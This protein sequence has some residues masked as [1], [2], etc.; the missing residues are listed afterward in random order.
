MSQEETN[1]EKDMVIKEVPLCSLNEMVDQP[2]IAHMSNDCQEET[3]KELPKN[4]PLTSNDD[5]SCQE[6]ESSSKDSRSDNPIYAFVL[7]PP[8]PHPPS[9]GINPLPIQHHLSISTVSFVQQHHVPQ[10]IQS[11]DLV[12]LAHRL[13]LNAF[14]LDFSLNMGTS[15]NFL[16][17][18]VFPIRGTLSPLCY[19]H[20]F[21][22]L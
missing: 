17:E 4:L 15:M 2:E 7:L 9:F 16:V 11:P 20:V 22:Q 14:L 10:S 6:D 3:S 1:Q 13:D 19:Q 12:W 8:D 21:K 5:L 18:N